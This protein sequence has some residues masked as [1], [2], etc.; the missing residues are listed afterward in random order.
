MV[1]SIAYKAYILETGW[2]SL[3]GL[4]G[5]LAALEDVQMAYLGGQRMRII[6]K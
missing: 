6:N 5:T 2:I 3:L 1:H 4:A